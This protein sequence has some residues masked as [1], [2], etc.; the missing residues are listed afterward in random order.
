M[1]VL[2]VAPGQDRKHSALAAFF[3]AGE[4]ASP[5]ESTDR[6]D[7]RRSFTVQ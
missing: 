2:N 4:T 1:E 5:H 6:M 3:G 7:H